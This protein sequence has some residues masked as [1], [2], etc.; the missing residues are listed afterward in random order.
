M[1]FRILAQYDKIRVMISS[2]SSSTVFKSAV[3][4]KS[5]RKRLK[6]FIEDE[7]NLN[8]E[9]GPIYICDPLTELQIAGIFSLPE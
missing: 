6:R 2:R 3:T 5:L 9:A 7:L 1:G 8:G 4:L